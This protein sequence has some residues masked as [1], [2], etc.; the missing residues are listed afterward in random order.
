MEEELLADTEKL[1]RIKLK[2]LVTDY[3][4]TKQNGIAELDLDQ[5]FDVCPVNA[6][7]RMLFNS[8]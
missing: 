4:K 5:L 3:V 6:V 2:S 7:T 1:I 8:T